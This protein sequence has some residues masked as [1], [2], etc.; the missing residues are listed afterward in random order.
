MT[1][2]NKLFWNSVPL[3]I[4]SFLANT[5]QKGDVI[6]PDCHYYPLPTSSWWA[7]KMCNLWAYIPAVSAYLLPLDEGGWN[8]HW[9]SPYLRIPLAVLQVQIFVFQ[10]VFSE[11]SV[12][13][14]PYHFCSIAKFVPSYLSS[15]TNAWWQHK[16]SGIRC[17]LIDCGPDEAPHPLMQLRDDSRF[18]LVAIIYNGSKQH[19]LFLT[20]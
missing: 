7:C 20:K 10:T 18:E 17:V 1:L 9:L 19:M 6:P 3:S 12:Q 4:S 8:L 14:I 2:E 16:S 5:K 13:H 15:S 11:P